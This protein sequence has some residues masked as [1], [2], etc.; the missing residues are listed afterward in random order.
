[1]R[2][3]E[4]ADAPEPFEVAVIGAGP[5][6]VGVLERLAAN[7]GET[8]G[9]DGTREPR[10]GIRVHLVDPHPP[11]GG[12]IWRYRQS[13][14][15]RM[16]SMPEDV[17]MYTDETVVMDGPVRP[18]PSL[19]EWAAAARADPRH[20]G[21]PG[22]L[23]AE[24][25]A[26]GADG[27]PTRRLQSAYLD[28]V[29]RRVAD[30]LPSGMEVRIHTTRA[31]DIVDRADGTQ[32]VVLDHGAAVVADAVLLTIGHIDAEPGAEFGEVAG[33]ARR[34]GLIHHP[35][36]YTAD[37][38]YSDVPGGEPAIV[39][40]LGLAFVDLMLL[41][42]EGRGGRF[43]EQPCGGLRYLP[44]G[45]EPLLYVGSGR[46]VPYHAKT[47]YRFPG[48]PP[49]L[50]RF[51]RGETVDELV[52]SGVPL[53]F[54][55]D[56][57][58][59]IAKELAWGHYAELFGAHPDR[60]RLPFES[61]ARA[62]AETEWDTPRMRALVE[63]AVPA[64]SDRLDLRSLDRPLAGLRFS[65][66]EELGKH[67]RD[68]IESDLSRRADPHFSADL[69]MFAA[70]LSVMGTL[71][72]LVSTGAVDG[73]SML[74][75][76]DRWWFG[77]FSY[78]ASGPPPRRLAELLALQEAGIVTFLGADTRVDLVEESGTFRA[79]SDSVPDTVD[80]ATLIE[81]RL[82]EPSLRRSVDPLLR[83]LLAGGG[84]TEET[85]RYNGSGST[86]PSG[87]IRTRVAD[88]R[89]VRPDGQVHPR[90]FALGPHTTAR[91]PG[92]FTRP[93]TNAASF[94]HNDR[95]AREI[96][97]LLLEEP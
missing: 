83:H 13:P 55:R 57:W 90:R 16:N 23:D 95:V 82:P 41:L 21:V 36:G 64:E 94:R 34:H 61:F 25:A 70:L 33:F 24:L 86:V 63:R 32:L 49:E 9:E 56:L 52:R 12:R 27:F 17:T 6:G 8:L 93:R 51:F 54:H 44:S 5:R 68:Y 1:M 3:R 20:F 66:I 10:R 71:L 84:L 60:V 79:G 39:R 81:A 35:P 2:D 77:F 62:F 18:G 37:V 38:D 87:R 76:V 28:W 80:A 30:T 45:R 50:P 11:G 69:G 19:H 91:S 4:Q 42:T 14:L 74:T 97:A 72:P 65:G 75:D 43:T 96:L 7:L 85:L 78:I 40:G 48:E 92:A 73:R 67:V 89:V 26:L 15:L 58:P 29:Y 47:G 88:G 53:D 22:E 59:H 46:G 31:V